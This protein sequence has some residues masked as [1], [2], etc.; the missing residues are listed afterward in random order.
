MK[1][2]HWWTS[3]T[4]A[5]INFEDI[6]LNRTAAVSRFIC[7]VNYNA[8]HKVK[9]AAVQSSGWG[10]IV[11]E[12]AKMAIPNHCFSPCDRPLPAEGTGLTG[13]ALQFIWAVR[14]ALEATKLLGIHSWLMSGLDSNA[15]IHQ[16]LRKTSADCINW[17]PTHNIVW[18][19]VLYSS[20]IVREWNCWVCLKY[21]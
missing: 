17:K 15:E 14:N 19:E 6:N 3:K 10:V 4:Q 12:G 18:Y 11:L 5:S 7:F 21:S 2:G 9:I 1:S 13:A 20:R 8:R 16:E